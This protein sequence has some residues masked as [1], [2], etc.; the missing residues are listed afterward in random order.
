MKLQSKILITIF[1]TLFIVSTITLV[2]YYY[3]QRNV[4]IKEAK[5]ANIQLSKVVSSQLDQLVKEWS[6]ILTYLHKHRVFIEYLEAKASGRLKAE[7]QKKAALEELFLTSSVSRPE[8]IEYI[9]FIDN[10]GIEEVLIKNQ[11]IRKEY[12]DHNNR[13]YYSEVIKAPA[14]KLS[15]PT[16]RK[17]EN[18]LAMDWGM[19]V[20]YEQRTLGVLTMTLNPDVLNHIFNSLLIKGIVDDAYVTTWEG[21]VLFNTRDSNTVLTDTAKEHG[22]VFGAL[23]GGETGVVVDNNDGEVISYSTHAPLG[24]R[25]M[26]STS[27]AVLMADTMTLLNRVALLLFLSSIPLGVVIV[28]VTR[29]MIVTRLQV[30]S[31][32]M[33]RI[34]Q[35]YTDGSN[36]TNKEAQEKIEALAIKEKD[37]LGDLSR[38]F[39]MMSRKLHMVQEELDIE[40]QRLQDLVKFGKLVGGEISEAECYSILIRYLSKSFNIDKIV[41]I[42]LNNSEDLAEVIATY[43]SDEGEATL[44]TPSC[45]DM[46]SIHSNRQCRAVRSGQ[47]FIVNDVE[48]EYRCP[49]QEVAQEHGSYMCA[50]ISTGG[51]TVGW[52]HLV[53]LQKNFFTTECN[54]MI[55]SYISTVAPAISSMRLVK[56]HRTMAIRDQLTGLYNRRFLEEALPT[57][58]A[59]ATR[60]TQPLSIIMIDIDHFKRFNDLYGHKQGDNI[61]QKVSDLFLKTVRESDIVARYGGEEFVVILPN[62]DKNGAHA[63]AEKIR[64]I[65]ETDTATN[66]NGVKERTTVS[67]GV[68]TY[69]EDGVDKD[70]LMRQVDIALYRSKTTGRN[71]VSVTSLLT[72][73]GYTTNTDIPDLKKVESIDSKTKLNDKAS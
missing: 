1:G 42:S 60:F 18:Y 70:E 21:T 39:I 8:L 46:K 33:A 51:S 58:F 22:E 55:N 3:I 17:G 26:L 44:S 15:Q 27:K 2:A 30:F 48:T 40:L 62:T 9:R 12:K 69:P 10:N 5:E 28:I 35:E 49:N 16:F 29:K 19:A 53:S 32:A 13:A 7:P 71:R 25:Y 63:L 50:P 56:A 37:E 36:I 11:E 64:S 57:Q 14:F 59:F 34:S 52:I 61:M 38:S 31:N 24:V 41:V 66:M 6:S 68:S 67:L 54:F 65:V 23:I 47:D 4:T 43:G 72:V 73:D 45:R 20:S